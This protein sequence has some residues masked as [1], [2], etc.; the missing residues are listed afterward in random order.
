MW[1]LFLAAFLLAAAIG[2]ARPAYAAGDAAVGQ[3]YWSG[4]VAPAGFSAC[5]GCHGA[6]PGTAPWIH[7]LNAA[8]NP[9]R[10]SLAI[11]PGITNPN[12]ESSGSMGGFTLT[13]QEREDI[14]AYIA[15]FVISSGNATGT[16]TIAFSYQIGTSLP[17]ANSFGAT[18]LPA[19]LSVNASTGEIT[20]T[21]T[22]AGSYPV[23]ISASNAVG[24]NGSKVVTFTINNPP[25]PVAGS[26]F[27]NVAFASL[28]NAIDLTASISGVT[29]GAGVTITVN[30]ANG[31]IDSVVGNVVTYTPNV[32]YFGNDPFSYTVAGPGGTSNTG[33]VTVSVGVPPAPVANAAARSVTYNSISN[34][35]DLTAAVT[36]PAT[37]VAVT[38]APANGT[39]NSVAGM[40]V[41]YTPNNGY[42]GPDTFSYTATG[43]GGGPSAAAVVTVTVGNPPAPV[44]AAASANVPFNTATP[45]NLTS[46]VTGVSSSIAIAS[47]PANGGT[48]IAGNVV[49]Y[50]PTTGY[51]GGDSFTYTATGPGGTSAAA[52]VSITV[53]TLAPTAGAA[54][55]AVPLN[56]ATTLNLAPFIT[57]SSI[58]GVSISANPAH[59]TVTVSGTNV[60]YT[61]VNNYFGTD[62]FSYQAYGNA[63]T[64]AAAAVSVTV[65]GRPDP[66]RDAAVTGLIG[67]QVDTAKRFSRAQIS[68]FQSRMESLHR[69]DVADE[70]GNR[71]GTRF[72]VGANE[73]RAAGD[74][75]QNPGKPSGAA[76][77]PAASLASDPMAGLSARAPASQA[78]PLPAV[79]SAISATL[80]GLPQSDPAAVLGNALL[81]AA[82]AM[83]TSSLNLSSSTG[84]GDGS[85]ML[86]DGVDVWIAGG[87]RFGTKDQTSATS[88]MKFTTD[89]VS[90]GADKRMS[91]E[92]AVG[93]GL[94]YAQ[95]KTNI[96][97]DGTGSSAKSITIAGYGSYQPTPNIYL[98]GLIGY[99][100]L[101]YHTDRYVTPIGQFAR[102]DRSGDFLFGSLTGGYEFRTTGLT[103]S[104]YGRF[105]VAQHRLK[106]A[107]ETGAGAFALTYADQK[108]PSVQFSLGLRADSAHAT[109][110]GWVAP[111]MRIE[112]QH[113]FKGAQ[114]A[115]VAYADLPGV[116]Y[117]LPGAAT[118][119]NSVVLGVG[120]D[121]VFRRGLTLSLDYQ[122]QRSSGQENSQAVMFRM[123]KDLDGYSAK[124]PANFS[125][126]GLGIRLDAGYMYDDNVSRS[127]KESE[128]LSDSAY[129]VNLGKRVLNVSLSEHSRMLANVFAGGEKF[130]RYNGLDRV[131][132]G[133]D[134]ELQ[135]RTSGD[136]SAPTFALF[137]NLTAEQYESDLRD[138]HRISGGVSVAKPLTDRISLFGAVARNWRYGRSAVFDTKDYSAR[139]NLDYALTGQSTF[140]LTREHRYGDIVSSGLPS[141]ENIN[142]ADVLVRDD[143]FTRPQYSNYRFDGVSVLSTVGFNFPVGSDDS[144][145]F[146]WRHISSRPNRWVSFATTTPRR[147]IVNQFSI[148]YLTKF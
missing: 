90:I 128:V 59:G 114:D 34:A 104:P 14:T 49:T 73:A 85:S 119:R 17:S 67:A 7:Q 127:N 117:V 105:D 103:L 64:S 36:N 110:F 99:G 21:P 1:N 33:V 8:N 65:T 76:Y 142:I 87:V 66:A 91:D 82:N 50:T 89:G 140:Y 12:G 143:V 61:P 132:A 70:P 32:T 15:T 130:R 57:G 35:L 68:N 138:G 54:T 29:N 101:D 2:F 145:D 97:I 16:E 93:A 146:S 148:V 43:P 121:F 109:S 44:A 47:A 129:S 63:G 37:S 4:A 147:Y 72:N 112:F 75:Q 111:R 11:N 27:P 62:I 95:D 55:M 83:Q 5:A 40:V 80:A 10:I 58:S 74:A 26:P 3:T 139:L 25:A 122:T 39:I 53:G 77:Q 100:R 78:N 98:D 136:F 94:G 31:T 56:T 86:A 81:F 22:A 69:R 48:S 41:T 71:A 123:T 92:L 108:S 19:G 126:W 144:I 96:G 20:G 120:S 137:G 88:A 115:T 52:T 42:F 38:V 18:G 134:A 9:G 23:T 51:S 125:K 13:L 60:I 116:R 6:T 24:G 107:T 28:S 133:A 118:N 141:L 84:R 45:I 79:T 131:F 124:M 113:D 30:P 135:Y 106:Q 102:S 46:S